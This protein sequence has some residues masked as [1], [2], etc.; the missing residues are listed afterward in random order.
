MIDKYIKNDT[1]TKVRKGI[2]CI[3]SNISEQISSSTHNVNHGF[4]IYI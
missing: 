2:A 4:F 3:D 1:K